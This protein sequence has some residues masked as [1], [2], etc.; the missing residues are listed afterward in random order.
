MSQQAKIPGELSARYVYRFGYWRDTQT[1]ERQPS[2]VYDRALFGF[3]FGGGAYCRKD[4]PGCAWLVE[5]VD[6]I[7]AQGKEE[8]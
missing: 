1:G 8:K 4:C 2:H 7:L 3:G 5:R 6:A